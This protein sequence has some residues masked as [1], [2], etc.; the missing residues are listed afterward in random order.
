MVHFYIEDR[1]VSA[2][3]LMNMPYMTRVPELMAAGANVA[4]GHGC[5]MNP[6]YGLGLAGMLEVA[7]MRS[8]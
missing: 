1:Y 6:W 5:A 3:P 4:F 2:G 8:Q 7:Q